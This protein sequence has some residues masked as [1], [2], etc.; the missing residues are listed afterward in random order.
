MAGPSVET[1]MSQVTVTNYRPGGGIHPE[2]A[3]LANA[4]AFKGGVAPHTGKPFTEEMLLGIGGGIGMG[5]AL[6][7]SKTLDTT[8][9]TLGLQNRWNDPRAYVHAIC[10][11]VGADHHFHETTGAKAA[12]GHL[13]VSLRDGFPAICWVDQGCLPY[14]HLPADHE[15]VMSWAVTVYGIDEIGKV[16]LVD[17]LGKKP[18]LLSRD[19]LQRARGRTSAHRNRLLTVGAPDDPDLETA[20]QGGIADCVEQMNSANDAVGL[21]SLL[22]WSKLVNDRRNR[23]GWPVLFKGGRGLYGV[24]VSL[25]EAICHHGTDGSGLRSMYADFL[26]ESARALEDKSLAAISRKYRAVGKRWARLAETAL[27]EETFSE[28]LD[29]IEKKNVVLRTQGQQGVRAIAEYSR[30][31][32]VLRQ[33]YNQ[34]SPLPAKAQDQLFGH[35]QNQLR[36]L[37]QAEREAVAALKEWSSLRKPA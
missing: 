17:D 29:L 4:L 24:L 22:K 7:E 18:F 20:V 21:K 34:R 33:S 6:V 9:V 26:S 8:S 31:L 28:T 1:T 23:K 15:G 19:Q 5:Y 37:H 30:R 32:E 36:D 10:R 13:E 12:W 25:H 3:T 11:R 2:T 35:L 16:A 27:P 14:L